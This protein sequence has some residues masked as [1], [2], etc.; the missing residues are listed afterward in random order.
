MWSRRAS[1]GPAGHPRDLPVSA[2]T[3]RQEI[4][5]RD[6]KHILLGALALLLTTVAAHAAPQY[7]VVT[8]FLNMRVGPGTG[9]PVLTVIPRGE[10]VRVYGCIDGYTWCDV[11]WRYDRGWVFAGYLSFGYAG[12][13][14]PLYYLGP[15][16]GIPIIPYVYGDYLERHYRYTPY[17]YELKR[18]PYNWTGKPHRDRH[19]V[20]PRGRDYEHHRKDRDYDHRRKTRE[21]DHR[22]KTRE[23]DH[24]RKTREYDHRSKTRTYDHRSKDQGREQH[25]YKQWDYD[26][27]RSRGL[28]R[29]TDRYRDRT[30]E[31]GRDRSW[32]R[33]HSRGGSTYEWDYGRDRGRSTDHGRDRSRGRTR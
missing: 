14:R 3:G 12:G 26:R 20:R 1:A 11:Q 4:D 15:L 28:D 6:M 17:Y 10:Q 18:W 29:T 27:H 13:G 8:A 19:H 9:Y 30:E 7:A 16:I 31:R 23:Y 2:G 33:D 21:Y 22:R 24:R 25:R 5:R 32:H